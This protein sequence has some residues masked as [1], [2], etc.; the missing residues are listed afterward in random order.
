[1][2]GLRPR[3]EVWM[4]LN[5][6]CGEK[7]LDGYVNVDACGEP[8]VRCDLASFPWPWPDGSVDEVLAE[9]FLEH[10]ADY[11]RTVLEVSR[12]LRPGGLFRFKVPHFRAPMGVWHLHRWSFSTHT[13][14]M[15]CE[16]LPY[17]FGGRRLFERVELR[18]NYPFIPKTHLLNRLLRAALTRLANL[19]PYHWDW[20]GLPI[21]EVEFCG[22]KPG[23]GGA[24]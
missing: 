16:R 2:R 15:L 9:H 6:G 8:D 18:V 14:L 22:R 10:V 13:P 19:S 21:D 5:L 4:R 12:V 7:R 20:L 24:A 1:M 3:R 17:Q 11:E 23:A